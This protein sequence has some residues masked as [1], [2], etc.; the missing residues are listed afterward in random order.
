MH[1]E[2]YDDKNVFLKIING[3][4]PCEKILETKHC[5]S[6]YSISPA[7]DIHALVVP[8]GKYTN[9]NSFQAEASI[10]EKMDLFDAINQVAKK[11]EIKNKGYKILSNVGKQ[12]AM[13]PHVHFH[14][15]H[16]NIDTSKT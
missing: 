15:L 11:L 3:T 16:G 12:V 4:I 5:I 6:F 1:K 2:I 7:A 13:I 14:V 9:F 8:K 10:E